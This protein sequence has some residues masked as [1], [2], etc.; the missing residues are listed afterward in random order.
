ME[1]RRA[2]R[3]RI[4]ME[5]DLQTSEENSTDSLTIVSSKL[6]NLNL[7][8]E[9]C[10]DIKR[11]DYVSDVDRK[12]DCKLQLLKSEILSTLRQE[13]KNTVMNSNSQEYVV[14]GLKS[15][16]EFLRNEI[17][18]LTSLLDTVVSCFQRQSLSDTQ[19]SCKPVDTLAA[20]EQLTDISSNVTSVINVEIPLGK[21][22]IEESMISMQK[23]L[24]DVRTTSHERYCNYKQSLKNRNRLSIALANES[25]SSVKSD[26]TIQQTQA[27]RQVKEPLKNKLQNIA[28]Y[29]KADI[30]NS[31]DNDDVIADYPNKITQSIPEDSLSRTTFVIG[32]SMVK[33]IKGK[34][35]KE[36]LDDSTEKYLLK[37]SQVPKL[38]K[39]SITSFQR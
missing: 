4:E 38:T 30:A 27:K 33:K 18:E 36:R 35:I 21:Q 14:S 3:T 23:Q 6:K 39:C 15:E 26:V 11:D 5:K 34:V 17:R 22:S 31:N 9:I 20:K 28:N 1:T 13:F 16:N 10:I 19:T 24:A 29:P 25:E 7:D 8:E 2:K 32:D 12:I 37:V